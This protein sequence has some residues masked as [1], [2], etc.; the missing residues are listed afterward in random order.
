MKIPPTA[1]HRTNLLLSLVAIS[2]L[3]DG[4]TL[5]KTPTGKIDGPAWADDVIG[6]QNKADAEKNEKAFKKAQRDD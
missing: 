5:F 1:A 6:Q 4:C 3:L 2:L